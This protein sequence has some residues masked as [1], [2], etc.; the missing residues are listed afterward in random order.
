MNVETPENTRHSADVHMELYINGLVLPIA[1][2]GPTFLV[3]ESAID[4][5]PAEAE[6][7]LRIDAHEE[8]WRVYLAEGVRHDCWKTLISRCPNVNGPSLHLQ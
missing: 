2:L 1:Q 7:M 6:I 8:R 4:H 3:L 5:P